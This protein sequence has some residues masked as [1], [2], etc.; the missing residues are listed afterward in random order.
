M[1]KATKLSAGILLVYRVLI[2]MLCGVFLFSMPGCGH[3]GRVAVEGTVTLEGQPLHQ[4]QIE[5]IPKPGTAAPT[6]GGDIVNGKFAIPPDKGPLVGKY[7]VKII[8][9]GSTGRKVRDIRSNTMI[10]EYAQIL[11]ARYN[12]QTELEAEVT[13]SGP[14][15]FEF[16]LTSK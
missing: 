5:F 3:K 14:N 12:E 7:R 9:S 13:S 2:V 4:A 11:P 10:D 8:K 16:T 15:I 6:V 1:Y